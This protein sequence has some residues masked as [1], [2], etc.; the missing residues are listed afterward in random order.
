[1]ARIACLVVPGVPHHVSQRGNR[2]QTTFFGDDVDRLYRELLAKAAG[3]ARAEVWAYCLMPS[4]V[5]VIL[6]PSDPD[7]LRNTVADLH[8]RYTAHI[9]ARNG[10]NGHLWQGR[11]GS[12][13]M[14]E[15]H[16]FAAAR[17]VALNPV[18]AGLATRAEDWPWSSARAH[19]AGLTT[20]WSK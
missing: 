14:D 15:A 19:L 12:V 10:W 20:A 16:L 18:R 17:Y 5:H 1:M 2:R 3:K 11:F 8:R 13:A 9:N 7:G 6:T 4:H